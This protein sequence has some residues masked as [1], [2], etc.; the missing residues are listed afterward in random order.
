MT[1]PIPTA[2]R[3]WLYVAGI[4]A[5]LLV[6]TVLPDLLKALAVE[7]VWVDMAIRATG[8]VTLLLSTL[9]RANLS[10]AETE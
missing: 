7:D 3:G 8:A 4:V 1:N 2:V 5:G 6:A 10:E 9:S